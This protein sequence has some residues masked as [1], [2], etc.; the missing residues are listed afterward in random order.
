MACGFINPNNPLLSS[1]NLTSK[2][3]A[4]IAQAIES[5]TAALRS[6]TGRSFSLAEYDEQLSG[7]HGCVILKEYPVKSID[8]VF[9]RLAVGFT[10]RN[11][12][13]AVSNAS[14][15]IADGVLSLLSIA[16]GVA[17]TDDLALADSATVGDLVDAINS[18]NG[19][20]A[21]VANGWADY[22]STDLLANQGGGAKSIQDVLIWRECGLRWSLDRDHGIL[23]LDSYRC[24]LRVVYTAGYAVIPADLQKLTADVVKEM[25]DPGSGSIVSESLGG[26]SYSMA[27]A[28]IERVP[29]DSKTI[30]SNLK[31]RRVR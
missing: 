1:L 30:L 27:T 25:F 13:T 15:T 6:A 21:T 7:Q 11:T 8:R 5:A 28:A 10:L 26:Y 24:L 19:W 12:D 18:V 17:S 29:I 20:S 22:P 14:Y 31:D 4:A 3:S 23:E 16:S 2:D 9:D